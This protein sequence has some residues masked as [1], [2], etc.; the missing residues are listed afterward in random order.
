MSFKILYVAATSS[1][2]AVLKR[3]KSLI[4]YS[5]GFRKGDLK[6]NILVT[7]VGVVPSAWS[8]M[9]FIMKKGKPDLAI[10][11]GIAGSFNDSIKTGDVVMP[12]TDCFADSG[13]EDRGQFYNVFEAGLSDPDD[14]PFEGGMLNANRQYSDKFRGLL[15]PAKAV[16]TN[17]ATGSEETLNRLVNKYNPDIETLEGASFFYIC[18][19]ERIP[20]FAVRSI[21]NKVEPRNRENWNIPLALGN[22]SLKLE[23][24]FNTL[25]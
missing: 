13:I 18:I 7:G 2:A 14:F 17:T 20:F 8:I 25:G 1:E 9:N 21:S 24:I 11:A 16:T 10:N 4:P 12:V 5:D 6:I 22:L 23:E 15:I 19:R 3:I